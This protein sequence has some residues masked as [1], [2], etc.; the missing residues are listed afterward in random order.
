LPDLGKKTIGIGMREDALK[1]SNDD[2]S[3]WLTCDRA[4]TVPC[5]STATLKPPTCAA[6]K[7]AGWQWRISPQHRTGNGGVFATSF[8]DDDA[9]LASLLSNLDGE[10]Q[11]EP[12]QLRFLGGKRQQIWTKLHRFWPCDWHS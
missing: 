10:K 1:V 6:A 12:L 3:H 9:A 7:E 5:A 4:C 11:A 2:W 8:I